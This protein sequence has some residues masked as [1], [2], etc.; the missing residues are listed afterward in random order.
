MCSTV[1]RYTVSETPRSD[2]VVFY[3]DVL[4]SER[5]VLYFRPLP[6]LHA[7]VALD[8]TFHC[9]WA[10]NFSPFKLTPAAYGRKVNLDVLRLIPYSGPGFEGYFDFT[11]GLN[12]RVAYRVRVA[13]NPARVM[14]DLYR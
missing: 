1:E 11:L 2:R 12:R 5:R 7:P 8:G 10:A 3:F 13:R 6:G 14:I 9:T 4:P